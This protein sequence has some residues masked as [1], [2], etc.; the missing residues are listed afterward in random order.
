MLAR[1]S[2]DICAIILCCDCCGKEVAEVSELE[3]YS[4]AVPMWEM[5][6]LATG[7]VP[8]R[9]RH[10][11]GDTWAAWDI[12]YKRALELAYE[13]DFRT[14]CDKQL[15]FVMLNRA[16]VHLIGPRDELYLF[17]G[18]KVTTLHTGAKVFTRGH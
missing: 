9:V 17:T 1:Y 8:S 15:A 5:V 14:N 4:G 6:P 12:L 18:V 2:P 11:L 7:E 3:I 16:C 10:M 13:D